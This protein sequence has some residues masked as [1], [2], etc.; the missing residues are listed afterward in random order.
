MS[1]RKREE[2][3]EMLRKVKR[4][5]QLSAISYQLLLVLASSILL[6]LSFPNFNLWPLAWIGL[7]PL[8]FAIENQK[9]LKAFF[10]AYI[11]GILFFLGTVWWL[12]HVTLPG[13]IFVILYLALYFGFFGLILS[14]SLQ[15]KA[16]S[17]LLVAPAAWVALEWLRSNGMFGFGWVLLSH[18]QSQ[19][20]P[21][22]QISDI[23]GAY[24]VS[25]LIV[26]VNVSIYAAVKRFRAK[27]DYIA[28]LAVVSFLIFACLGYGYFRLNNIFTG[29]KLKVSV[30]QG[31][32]PQD[33]K[34]DRDFREGILARYE[35][36][37]KKAAKEK[38]DL[39]VWPETSVP[40]FLESERDLFDRVKALAMEA[41]APLLVGT[42]RE[43][44]GAKGVEY[45]NSAVLFSEEGRVIDR[46]DKIHLVPFGEYIPFK[47]I[48]SFVEKFAP[49]PIGDCSQGRDYKTFSFF[50]ERNSKNKDFNW[51]LVKK[52]RFSALIC[53]EDIF[54]GL[55]R[56]FVKNGA[57]FLVNITN[58]AWYKKTSAPFQH[59]ASSVFRAVEYRVNVVRAAN[60]GFSCFIDQ[61]GRITDS[62][63]SNGDI[64]VE[65]FKSHEIVLTK[66]RTLYGI[67][68]DIFSYV[69]IVLTFVFLLY[70]TGLK[71]AVKY[72]YLGK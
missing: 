35:V 16:Y 19:N 13:M 64:F 53:F 30:V 44:P 38:T 18:S 12:I 25:Y 34:W 36:L 21:I 63:E 10:L 47:N 54:P 51:R 29:E 43:G 20:L 15:L 7:I 72:A 52:V 5:Y 62:V 27:S 70:H 31:N 58:D 24:G 1:L 45:Y 22:I 14:Y 71:L 69:C 56:E 66:T 4:S 6:T 61:K 68:G 50:I 17:L 49:I 67:Y 40:G 41:S 3:Q 9:P 37:T 55:V 8:L 42:V 23:T 57:T 60:T 33:E 46:Y 26:I 59:A 48:F 28:P 11:T 65:G 39:I 2:I 32:I